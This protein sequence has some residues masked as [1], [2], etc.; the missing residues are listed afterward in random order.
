ME[1][2][3]YFPPLYGEVA[4][5]GCDKTDCMSRSK[6][7]RRRRDFTYTSGRC[8]RL[9]DSLG[10]MEKSEEVLYASAFPVVYAERACEALFLTLTI[11][12]VK[13]NRRVYHTKSGYWCFR[14]KT[15]YGYPAKRVISIDGYNTEKDILDHMERIDTDYC[16][17]RCF[18]EDYFI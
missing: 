6:Y 8:P 7:Q 10:R 3:P 18:I 17:F 15:S 4:C 1:K 9:P 5:G 12:G 16:M 11:P 2:T 14:D 13:Q